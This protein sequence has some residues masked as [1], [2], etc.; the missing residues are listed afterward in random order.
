MINYIVFGFFLIWLLVLS[1]VIFNLKRHYYNLILRTKKRNIDDILD[2]L[3]ET[4]DNLK[5]EISL[6]KKELSEEIL[7]S[8]FHFQKIG[9]VRFN[10]FERMG[11]EQSFV[12]ALLDGKNNGLTINF[13]YTRDGLR[14]YT[15]KVKDGKGEEY[16]LSEEEKKAIQNSLPTNS[17]T[18]VT[19]LNNKKVRKT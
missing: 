8:K 17:L 12:L 5:K 6:I 14:V 11:G 15:K 7:T 3:L 4:D 13:I 9:L 10:P 2:Q 19:Q 1:F 16:E 18:S